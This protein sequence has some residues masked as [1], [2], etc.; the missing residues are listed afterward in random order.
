MCVIAGIHLDN[1]TKEEIDKILENTMSAVE[2][3]ISS[4]GDDERE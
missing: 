1:I 2:E 4:K 3:F